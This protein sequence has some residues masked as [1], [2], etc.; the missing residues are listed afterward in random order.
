MSMGDGSA[1]SIARRQAF[2]KATA[3]SK[4]Q[5]L[6]QAFAGDVEIA[7][8]SRPVWLPSRLKAS[9]RLPAEKSGCNGS[10]PCQ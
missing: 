2:P 5:W 8:R 6:L 1:V 7:V 10:K 9:V 3:V 4:W